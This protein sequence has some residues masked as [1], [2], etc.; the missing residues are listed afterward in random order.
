MPIDL[1]VPGDD[2]DE[3]EPHAVVEADDTVDVVVAERAWDAAAGDDDHGA[4]TEVAGTV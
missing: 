1:A 3:V 4:E 2:T